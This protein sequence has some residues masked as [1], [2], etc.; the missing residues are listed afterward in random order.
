MV[1]NHVYMRL[2]V[3]SVRLL[4]PVIVEANPASHSSAIGLKRFKNL[5]HVVQASIRPIVRRYVQGTGLVKQSVRSDLTV[6]D[7]VGHLDKCPVAQHAKIVSR[8]QRPDERI[9]GFD[10]AKPGTASTSMGHGRASGRG[11]LHHSAIGD[12]QI[13]LDQPISEIVHLGA[14]A[15]CGYRHELVLSGQGSQALS[16]APRY[17]LPGDLA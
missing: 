16:K 14:Q 15:R 12:G 5:D 2:R 4:V 7:N 8:P 6:G 3:G 11:Q 17:G 9:R 10:P 1:I 13:F